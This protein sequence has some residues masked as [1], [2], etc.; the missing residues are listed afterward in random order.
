MSVLIHQ[1]ARLGSNVNIGAHVVIGG[2]AG[3]LD[4]PV[5]E[6]DVDLSCNCCVLGDIT[7]G[8]GAVIG[9]GAVVICDVEPGQVVAGVPARPI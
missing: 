6:D 2:R 4:L 3:H 5:I 1:R 7:V 8:R 9:A